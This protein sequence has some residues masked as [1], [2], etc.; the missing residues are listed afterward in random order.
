MPSLEA[1]RRWDR[2]RRS[3]SQAVHAPY[4]PASVIEEMLAAHWHGT[5]SELAQRSGV[6]GRCISRIARGTQRY[7]S[8]DTADRISLA[9][10]QWL[11]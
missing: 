11:P 1:T 3:M 10:G 8:L 2:S 5:R 6:S 4:Y 7:V 9:L